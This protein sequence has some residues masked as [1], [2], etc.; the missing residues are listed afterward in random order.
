MPLCRPQCRNSFG[1]NFDDLY[2]SHYCF[3]LIRKSFSFYLW[4]FSDVKETVLQ[5]ETKRRKHFTSFV[6][7]T[8][9]R[10]WNS[11]INHGVR[12][13]FPRVVIFLHFIVGWSEKVK[14]TRACNVLFCNTSGRSYT[15]RE[16]W[17]Q[18]S[19]S[20]SHTESRSFI[21]WRSK[22]RRAC[23]KKIFT[24]ENK[25]FLIHAPIAS[26]NKYRCLRASLLTSSPWVWTPKASEAENYFSNLS[27]H[28]RTGSDIK[29]NLAQIGHTS[30]LDI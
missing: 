5:I 21:M 18:M 25:S 27:N 24:N 14:L 30:R 3:I 11:E 22:W 6:T 7:L 10:M 23:S 28:R 9:G 1:D 4:I 13:N 2:L 8:S 29:R 26:I 17:K 15:V 19:L 16:M 12:K 20:Y